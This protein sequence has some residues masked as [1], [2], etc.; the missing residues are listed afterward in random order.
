MANLTEREKEV[1]K[2]VAGDYNSYDIA[3]K[4]IIS[5]ET[6]QKHFKNLRKKLKTKSLAG[7]LGKA[8]FQRII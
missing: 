3:R 6:V 4:L 1:L 7:A 5:N 8:F 2:L